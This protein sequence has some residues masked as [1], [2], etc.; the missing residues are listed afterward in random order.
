MRKLLLRHFTDEDVSLAVK[1][2]CCNRCHSICTCE[3]QK[4]STPY[5]DFDQLSDNSTGESQGTREVST[6]DKQC[7]KDALFEV[8]L[9]L[10]LSSGLTLFDSSGV[11]THGFSDNVVRQCM[12]NSKGMPTTLTREVTFHH[13]CF[14]WLVFIPTTLNHYSLA[15]IIQI[16]LTF[17]HSTFPF[18][19]SLNTHQSPKRSGRVYESLFLTQFFSVLCNL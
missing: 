17:C 14:F 12:G 9:S 16:M 8:Q 1:H 19:V 18:S 13:R 3:G 2:N 10:D 6:E 15:P 4:C 11:I 7:L 5:F